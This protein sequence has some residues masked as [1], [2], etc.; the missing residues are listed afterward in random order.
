MKISQRMIVVVGA[1][2]AITAGLTAANRQEAKNVIMILVDDYGWMDV[3]CYGSKYYETPNIDKLARDG[4]LFTNGYAACQVSSPSRASIMTGQYTTRHRITEWIGQK[5]GEAWRKTNRHTKLLS[6]PYNHALPHEEVTIAEELKANGYKTLM[7][8]KWHLG[9]AETDWPEHH[10]FDINKGGWA[11]GSPKGGYFSPYGNPRLEDG[12]AG[13]NLSMRLSQET[14]NFIKDHTKK[15]KKQ[16]YFAY[17]AFYAVH[18]PIETTQENWQYFRDKAVAMGVADKGYIVDRTLPVR[19]TQDNPVYAGLIKQ[20]DDAVGN[21]ID[22]LIE[23]GQYDNTLIMFTGD[24]GGVSSGDAFSSSMLPLRGGKGRQWEGGIRVPYIVKMPGAVAKNAKCDVPVTG[25]DFY[26]TIL[27][28]AKLPL[29]PQQ[30]K[31]GVSLMPLF[32]GGDIAERALYWHYPHYSNQGGD[33]SSIIRKGDWKL[34]YY[35]EDG[36]NELYNLALDLT[37]CEPLNAQYPDKVRE[38]STQL[39]GWLVET[40]AVMPEAD[41]EYDPKK[42]QQVKQN[43]RTKTLQ[44]RE[45]ERLRMLQENYQPNVDWW[46]SRVMD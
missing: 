41:A 29:Q 43:W 8:G 21:L 1:T 11:A 33:P 46:E 16:P 20:M 44:Q 17:L 5:S 9:D 15:N 18:G 24:N 40:G 12:P 28:F 22:Y 23:S 38:L 42:E 34:I 45:N 37:E 19:Q 36:R 35:H 25:T 26:P 4:M 7:A 13:E 2:S 32:Q 39:Q 27:S 6:A 10:G 30:H 3:G 31:D 14:V